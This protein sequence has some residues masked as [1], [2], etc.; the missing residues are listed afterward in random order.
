MSE[1][2]TQP[3]PAK[4]SGPADPPPGGP[5]VTDRLLRGL[6]HWILPVY[7]TE[8]GGQ[9]VLVYTSFPKAFYFYLV[10]LPGF[11]L[12]A[13]NSLGVLPDTQ[14][15]W[16]MFGFGFV[17]YL[18]IAE[19]TSPLGFV[20]LLLS[21]ITFL[22]L[23]HGGYLAW[24]GVDGLVQ[25]LRRVSFAMDPKTLLALN[26]G[27]LF[28]WIVVY[29]FSVTWKKRELSSLRR[30][31]LRPPLGRRPL[32]IIGRV[33]DNKVRDVFE[34]ILGFGAYDVEIAQ[35]GGKVIEVDR[36]CVGLGTKLRLFSDIISHIPTREEAEAHAIMDEDV[37]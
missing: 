32:P 14:V 27:L 15:I 9:R 6:L 24:A 28:V 11:V 2:S 20:I 35:A 34:L 31:K 13:L 12:L 25:A 8:T 26:T 29:V 33:V 3:Q 23:F 17:A 22:V 10:W 4:P 16:W 36:N 21:F 37:G 1:T 7:A 18:V 19:D 30:S 5:R